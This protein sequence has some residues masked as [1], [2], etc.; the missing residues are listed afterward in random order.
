MK[1]FNSVIVSFILLLIAVLLFRHSLKSGV[2]F[3]IFLIIM[4]L[5]SYFLVNKLREDFQW[6]ITP[7]DELPVLSREGLNKFIKSGYDEE[8]GWIRKP[9]TEKEEIGKEGKTKYHIDSKGSRKNPGHEKLPIKI[10]FYGDSFLF[11]RQVND[12]ESCQWHMSELTKT[13]I[14]NFSVGNYGMDQALLRLKREYPKNKTKIVV[15]G[16]V[17]ATIVRILSVWKHYNEYGNT[18]GFKPRFE[19]KNGELMLVKNFIDKEEKFPEYQKYINQIRKHDYFYETKFKKEMI[20][21]PYFI[22]ILSDPLRNIPLIFHVSMSKLSKVEKKIE[23]YPQ[24]MELIMK[25][26]LKLRYK[27][28][29]QNKNAVKLFEKLIDDFVA[30]SKKNHFKPVFL[31]MP[32][33]DDLLLIRQSGPYYGEFI[34]KVGKKLHTIDLTDYL[35]DRDDLDEIYSDDNEYGGHYSKSGNKVIAEMIYRNFKKNKII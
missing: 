31:F 20:E 13:N 22:S 28:F 17:P 19:I 7:K 2:G 18:F 34:E 3:L 16:V 33:K 26:N 15:M 25:I 32:Q 12:N 8:L 1:K 29:N 21:F 10:S 9:N 11:A 6:L 30:Y 5:I 4:E 35:L 23:E 27:L 14:P 24:S